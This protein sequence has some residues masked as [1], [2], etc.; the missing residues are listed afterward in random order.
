[1]QVAVDSTVRSSVA[2]LMPVGNLLWVTPNN[3]NRPKMI[4]GRSAHLSST[5]TCSYRR[6]ATTYSRAP[7][8]YV[9]HSS[10]RWR[11]RSKRSLRA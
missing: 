9:A 3:P 4:G 7:L 6:P 10:I 5:A 11:R 8:R 1:M 2:A